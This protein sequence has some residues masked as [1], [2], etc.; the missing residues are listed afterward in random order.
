MQNVHFDVTLDPLKTQN[1]K[2]RNTNVQR[3]TQNAKCETP[4]REFV[5]L[6][7]H[8]QSYER[9]NAVMTALTKHHLKNLWDPINTILLVH[10]KKLNN[11]S[12]NEKN[13]NLKPNVS[14][15]AKSYKAALCN[16][17]HGAI[18]QNSSFSQHY[19]SRKCAYFC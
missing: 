6:Q 10:F 9:E 5:C 14:Y 1:E 8:V 19:L 4:K 15:S 13:K 17:M 12:C 16:D 7:N 2:H 3:N 18:L 11:R